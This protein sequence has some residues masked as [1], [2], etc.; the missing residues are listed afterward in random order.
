MIYTVWWADDAFIP[1]FYEIVPAP[2]CIRMALNLS[3][4][5]LGPADPAC[6]HGR[7]GSQGLL[8]S[9]QK[10]HRSRL[11]VV[12]CNR[13][14][15]FLISCV[16]ATF[17]A[18]VPEYFFSIDVS[19]LQTA[20]RTERAG[21]DTTVTR[22]DKLARYKPRRK[23]QMRVLIFGNTGSPRRGD[24]GIRWGE[25]CERK[26][27]HNWPRK[28]R[29]GFCIVCRS[30]TFPT[31]WEGPCQPNYLCSAVRCHFVIAI[32]GFSSLQTAAY[33]LRVR[34]S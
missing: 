10:H 29:G 32:V 21:A 23:V 31:V 20:L 19:G 6:R 13:S 3:G 22:P 5:F 27:P 30:P 33:K 28:E 11:S 16:H 26:S 1:A 7:H 8:G 15:C 34:E 2:V 4:M 25:N 17:F 9:G 12:L 24:L 18:W 14:A